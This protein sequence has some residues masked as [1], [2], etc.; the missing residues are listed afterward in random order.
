M[1]KLTLSLLLFGVFSLSAMAQDDLYFIPGKTVEKAKVTSLEKTKKSTAQEQRSATSR[2]SYEVIDDKPVYHSGSNREVDEYNR[3]GKFGSYFT[4]IGTDSLGNDIIEFHTSADNVIDTL[5][6][7][8]GTKIEYNVDED[9]AYS[10]RLSRFDDYYWYDPWLY[11]YYGF[12]P[13]WRYRYGFYNPWY[14]PWYYGYNTWYDP[15]FYGYGWY[16]PWYRS[17]YYGWNYPYYYSWNYGYY[18]GWSAPVITYNYHSNRVSGTSHHGV[19][20]RPGTTVASQGN[21]GGYR[22]NGQTTR[23]YNRSNNNNGTGAH[24]GNNRTYSNSY[25]GTYSNTSRGNYSNGTRSTTYSSGNASRSSGSYSTGSSS[26]RSSGGSFS[27]GSSGGGGG[28][29]RSG[30][31]GGGHLGGRR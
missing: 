18:G 9:Y 8:P 7:Y 20:G 6:I 21:Y 30:G 15:W 31:G 17:Y 5:S 13:Y 10:R 1:K 24:F 3:H 14:D 22:G 25:G 19:A 28:S 11:S 23:A 4:K 12:G 2:S 26:S 27:S 29:S 16:D